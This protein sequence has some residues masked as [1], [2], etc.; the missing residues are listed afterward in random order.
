[1]RSKFEEGVDMVK[2]GAMSSV[3]RTIYVHH[4]YIIN[5]I[6]SLNLLKT[7]DLVWLTVTR[8]G[9]ISNIHGNCELKP[10]G[11]DG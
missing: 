2:F 10:N 11:R 1:M 3:L 6:W 8:Q 7:L 9:Y 5:V 4:T